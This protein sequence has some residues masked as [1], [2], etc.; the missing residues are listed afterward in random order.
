MQV[1]SWSQPLEFMACQAGPVQILQLNCMERCRLCPC[2]RVTSS[3]YI[4][5]ACI[6][7]TQCIFNSRYFLSVLMHWCIIMITQ[8]IS[9]KLKTLSTVMHFKHLEDFQWTCV[10][11]CHVCAHMHAINRNH[12]QMERKMPAYELPDKI[13]LCHVQ[14]GSW[15]R[16]LGFRLGRALEPCD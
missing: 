10:K 9:K 7:C 2:M 11:S 15:W 6:K 1:Q 13:C 3:C 12:K 16:T 8:F 4:K 14:N 5:Y